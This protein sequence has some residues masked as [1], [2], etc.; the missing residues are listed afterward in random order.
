MG[1]IAVIFSS[2]VSGRLKE[3]RECPEE[4]EII[5]FIENFNFTE[6]AK[7]TW[8]VTYHKNSTIKKNLLLGMIFTH[9]NILLIS[10]RDASGLLF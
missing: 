5:T 7:G 8:Y 6:F 4:D 10:F 9:M 3:I 2:G 1:V